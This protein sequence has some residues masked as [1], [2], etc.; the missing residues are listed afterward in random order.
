MSP[1][2]VWTEAAQKTFEDLKRRFCS[3]PILTLPDLSKPFVVEVDASDSGVGGI[4]S[5][6]AVEDGKLHPCAFFSRALS[7]AEQN[8]GVGN[9]ELLAIKLAVEEWRHWL[10]GAAD[11]FLIYTDHKTWSISG[12]RSNSTPGRLAGP[13][14]FSHFNYVVTYRPGSKNGKADALSRL[15]T[16]EAEP[17]AQEPIIPP[18]RVMSSV[19][20]FVRHK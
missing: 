2:L 14:F 17:V 8:Y 1:Q 19:R 4:L 15:H 7:P 11:P 5:Q 3:A 9:R 12:Y 6:R 13:C 16:A 20:R 18:S 10:K